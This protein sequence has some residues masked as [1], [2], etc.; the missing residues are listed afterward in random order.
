MP[1]PIRIVST[2][3]L[4][5]IFCFFCLVG[6]AQE[7]QMLFG[8]Q[9]DPERDRITIPF[10]M[11]SNLMVI[12]LTLNDQLPLK[13]VVDSGVRTPI[14]T[15]KYLSDVVRISYDREI[16]LYSA[17]AQGMAV[18]YIAHNVDLSLPGGIRADNQS[19]YVLKEDFIG[20]SEVLGEKVHGVI[21]YDLFRDFVVS[22]DYSEYEITFTR[23]DKF[24]PHRFATSYPLSIENY[25]AYME[26]EVKLPNG[27]TETLKLLLDT[28]ASHA[29]WLDPLEDSTQSQ[30]PE[31]TFATLVGRGL[32]GEINGHL[33]RIEQLTMGKY[34]FENVLTSFPLRSEYYD[35]V[36]GTGRDGSLGS[37]VLRRFHVTFD[38]TH[39]TLYLLR[40]NYYDDDF[41]FNM[42]GLNVVRDLT[43]AIPGFV[44]DKVIEDS[45]A[46]EAG[47]MEG[48]IILNL[49][50]TSYKQ[51]SLNGIHLLLKA[52]EGKRIRITVLRNGT[53]IKKEFRLRSLI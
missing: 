39:K 41:D 5:L 51:L 11:L 48:D 43:T 6:R 3:S 46:G 35:I 36:R 20:L 12:E 16:E 27:A 33:G 45:P 32:S 10:Q 40:N 42:S 31:T 15:D 7:G 22:V 19:I 4:S 26:T 14:L 24:R 17:G 9:M 37:E 50:G 8:F 28:G 1:K 34:G 38:Y 25:K 18:A 30:L 13:F 29:L 53:E 21:G 44:V 47:L 23:P 52:R 2:F 49:N